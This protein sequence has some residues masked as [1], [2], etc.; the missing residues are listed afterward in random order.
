MSTLGNIP[1]LD[2]RIKDLSLPCRQVLA[3]IGRSQQPC[4]H[5]G[6]V[7]E[8]LRMLGQSDG[9]E[10]IK[11]LFETGL[12]FPYFPTPAGSAP[13]RQRLGSLSSWVRLSTANLM[14]FVPP[15]VSCRALKEPLGCQPG[16]QSG[17]P[18]I[19][20]EDAKLVMREADG[21]DWPLRLAVLWQMVSS[22]SLRRTLH[23][24]FFKRDLDRLRQDPLLSSQPH[25]ALVEIPDPALLAV[26]L[27][28]AVGILQEKPGDSGE[29]IA[30]TFPEAW[31]QSLLATLA[32]F[33]SRL[34]FLRGWDGADGWQVSAAFDNLDNPYPA[35]YLVGLLLLGQL[36]EH[37]WADPEAVEDWLLARH[38]Y[39]NPVP[40][41][42]HESVAE[43]LTS[44][45]PLERH[46]QMGTPA[47]QR[48]HD[49]DPLPKG[50]VTKFLL[51][52]A[53]PLRLLR[54]TKGSH[55]RWLVQLSSIGRWLLGLGEAPAGLPTYP[56]TL[57]VQPNLE[58]LAYRQGLTPDLIVRLSRFAT[59]KGV[60]AACTL[61]IEPES[62]YRALEAGETFASL[63]RV[64]EQHGMKATPAPVIESLRT[65]SN[66]RDRIT[67]YPTGVLLEFPGPGE[68]A[69]ALARGLPAV[70]LSDRLAILANEKDIDFRHFKLTGTRDYAA[71]PEQCVDVGEDGVT[72]S[73]DLPRSDLLLETELVRFAEP[74]PLS[75]ATPQGR[76]LYRVTPASMA[77][78]KR[79]FVGSGP[80]KVVSTACQLPAAGRRPDVAHRSRS[81][82]AV[83]RRQL[84]LHVSCEKVA[85]GLMQWPST[86]ALIDARLGPVALSVLAENAAILQRRATRSRHGDNSRGRSGNVLIVSIR[87]I[88]STGIFVPMTKTVAYNCRSND[89][90]AMAFTNLELCNEE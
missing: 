36:G 41:P 45:G 16:W 2:R 11:M 32:S 64:L 60:A 56:Q 77:G 53:F 59:W 63:V 35:L 86:R 5:A 84:V 3:L 49:D 65:W 47:P 6:N 51:G 75:P 39:W 20:L 1:V 42:A 43:A 10:P 19:S 67:I 57:L 28:L 29:L 61:Q 70:R 85:D 17:L 78:T 80:G 82:A 83:L 87:D 46:A 73:I 23:G 25:D 71:P 18:R 44:N 74:L 58:I 21:L 22:G 48:D 27:A 37:E 34:P 69:D 33:W 40:L 79:R 4:W 68:L 66:K 90:K 30:G 55:G 81:T 62:V 26:S 38:P 88:L 54:A 89:N 52:L 8:M 50:A 76:K 12:L 72:L 9:L 7:I 15:Q 14:L 13:V 31:Q 24:D